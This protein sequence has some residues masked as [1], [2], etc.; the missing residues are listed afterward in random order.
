MTRE[1]A[2]AVIR[3]YGPCAHSGL[4]KVVNSRWSQ[5]E[6]CG[7]G[8]YTSQHQLL[9]EKAKSFERALAILSE[10]TARETRE[11][12]DSD[13]YLA[14]GRT[15]ARRFTPAE[16]EWC[17]Q[18]IDSVRGCSRKQFEASEDPWLAQNVISSRI[19]GLREAV[20]KRY[21]V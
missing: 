7:H 21:N 14:I 6:D 10:P 3:Q 16:R 12:S 4:I 18:Q 1:E 8:F 15:I 11:V 9:H 17:L 2:V 13:L 5:C 19:K 20:G